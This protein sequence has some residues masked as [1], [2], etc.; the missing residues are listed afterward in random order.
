KAAKENSD[1]VKIEETKPAV[2]EEL[3]IPGSVYYLKRN[4]ESQNDVEKEVYT[5]LKRQPGEHFQRI[6]LSGNFITD[7]KCDSHLYALRDVLKGLPWHGKE[8]IFQ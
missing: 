7:H 6:I 8:G 5:L 2:S 4:L 1:V 3:F